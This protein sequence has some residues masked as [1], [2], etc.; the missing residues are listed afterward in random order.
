MKACVLHSRNVNIKIYWV[1]FIAGVIFI[2][3]LVNAVHRG[4][5]V[6]VATPDQGSHAF[7]GTEHRECFSWKSGPS[8]AVCS[9]ISGHQKNMVPCN[10]A[11]RERH[12]ILQGH[13]ILRPVL[14]HTGLSSTCLISALS[15]VGGDSAPPANAQAG[16]AFKLLPPPRLSGRAGSLQKQFAKE[17]TLLQEKMGFFC[18]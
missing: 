5:L 8:Q 18:G 15:W 6:K 12:C 16:R 10:A 4:K 17:R 3:C 13:S 1:A 14:S 7:R 2:Q 11:G 9:E